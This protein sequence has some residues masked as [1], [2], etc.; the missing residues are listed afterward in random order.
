[1]CDRVLLLGQ[2]SLEQIDV[3]FWQL[4]I[5]DYIFLGTSEWK[6]GARAIR[7]PGQSI[8]GSFEN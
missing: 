1:M 2:I 4:D 7:K 5:E 3:I 6:A 8:V